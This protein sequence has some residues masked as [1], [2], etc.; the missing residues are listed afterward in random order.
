MENDENS[1]T[2][3]HIAKV[4]NTRKGRQKIIIRFER[5]VSLF[6]FSTVLGN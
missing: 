1:E 6:G 4:V 3:R 5:E 2:Q